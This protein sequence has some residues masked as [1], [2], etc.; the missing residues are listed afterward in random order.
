[1]NYIYISFLLFHRKAMMKQN[2]TA[3]KY[4]YVV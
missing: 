1:M 2:Y 3:K 4:M